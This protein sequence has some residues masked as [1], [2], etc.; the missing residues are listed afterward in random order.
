MSDYYYLDNTN[1]GGQLVT[2]LARHVM[3]MK[4]HSNGGDKAPYVVELRFVGGHGESFCFDDKRIADQFH[5]AVRD[6]M[7]SA[8]R[9]MP[10]S[11]DGES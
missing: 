1:D 4:R 2:G 8:G 11:S 3:L 7:L 5:T 6:S 10:P 9:S